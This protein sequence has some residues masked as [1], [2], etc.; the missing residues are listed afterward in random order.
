MRTP[1]RLAAAAR[2][3]AADQSAATAVEYA[4]MTFIAIAIVAAISA[5]GGS[6]TAMYEQLKGLFGN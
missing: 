5:L 3:F 4:V 6:V 2:R 1:V